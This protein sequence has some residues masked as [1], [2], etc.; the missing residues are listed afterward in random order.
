MDNVEPVGFMATAQDCGHGPDAEIGLITRWIEANLGSVEH[1]ER[2]ARWRPSWNADV[3]VNGVLHP[4]HARGDRPG[5]WRLMPLSC[6]CKV[7]ELFGQRGVRIP[8][9]LVS[10]RNRPAS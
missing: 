4:V 6:E 10:S 1:I 5:N 7:F 3:R 9:F 2:M 8:Q